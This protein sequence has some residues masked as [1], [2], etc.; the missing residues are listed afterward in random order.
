MGPD[1]ADGNEGGLR[2]MRRIFLIQMVFILWPAIWPYLQVASHEGPPFPILV[3]RKSGSFLVSVWT[4]PDLGEGKF[5]LDFKSAPENQDTILPQKVK[6]SAHHLSQDKERIFFES[7]NP[8]LN[9]SPF[10]QGTIPFDRTGNWEVFINWESDGK[11]G[12]GVSFQVEVT[13]PGG[14]SPL[15]FGL[16]LIPFIGLAVLGGM[17]LVKGKR[18]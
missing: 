14:P 10:F 7:A 3:N 4:D 8:G 2:P 17:C 1:Q 12:E 9:N 15:D 16:I 13:P 11:R 5:F 6:I 18:R